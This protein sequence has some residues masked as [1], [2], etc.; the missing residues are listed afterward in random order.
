MTSFKVGDL[1]RAKR[2]SIGKYAITTP[3]RGFHGVVVSVRPLGEIEV[4]GFFSEGSC[5]PTRYN[6]TLLNPKNDTS[7]PLFH[8]LRHAFSN[9]TEAYPEEK[10]PQFF[11]DTDY[12]YV[13][14]ARY[15][16]LA[17]GS[18]PEQIVKDAKDMVQYSFR[19]HKFKYEINSLPPQEFASN[20]KQFLILMKHVHSLNVSPELRP[21]LSL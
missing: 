4:C 16:E 6:K 11:M 19:E 13:V 9:P 3:I 21:K 20:L 1:V 7:A 8:F 2:D 5:N 18:S 12:A 17:N 15:F 14:E 10:V